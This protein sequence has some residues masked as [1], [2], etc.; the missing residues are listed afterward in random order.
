MLDGTRKSSQ[1][2]TYTCMVEMIPG[3]EYITWKGGLKKGGER[4][5]EEI[6]VTIH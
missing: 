2:L 6:F 3:V 1:I 4:K 5:N